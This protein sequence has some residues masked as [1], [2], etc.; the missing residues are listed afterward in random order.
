MNASPLHC[1]MKP[2]TFL[3][4][5]RA[6]QVLLVLIAA[7]SAWVLVVTPQQRESR[8][9]INSNGFANIAKDTT[10]DM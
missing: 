2:V 9:E 10:W 7:L 6:L 1:M 5:L 3:R 4:L 8:T